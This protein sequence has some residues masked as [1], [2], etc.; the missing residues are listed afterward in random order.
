MAGADGPV[1][2]LG[3]MSGTSMDGADA[4]LLE[5]DGTEI[6]RLGPGA[7]L[8]Y[9]ESELAA[10]RAVMADPPAFRAAEGEAAATLA[11][12]ERAV[13]SLQARA[14]VALLAGTVPRDRKS[15]V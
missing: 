13:V 12:A 1:W 2:A 10:L 3:L 5:T 6:A 9:R 4:A 14:A 11:E 15:V 8:H 7:V